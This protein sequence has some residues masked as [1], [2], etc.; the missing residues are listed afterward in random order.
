[1]LG[2]RD[3]E[4]SAFGKKGPNSEKRPPLREEHPGPPFRRKEGK[5]VRRRRV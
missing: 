5:K 1:M 4:P 2:V 3:K